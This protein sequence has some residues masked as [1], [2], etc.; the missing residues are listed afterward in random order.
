MKKKISS[1]Q[2]LILGL[3]VVA[4]T[5][6]GCPALASGQ[7]RVENPAR[8]LAKNAGR[9]VHL[10][11]ALRIRDNGETVVFKSPRDFSLGPDGSLFFTDFADGPRLYRFGPRG[12]LVYR[13]LKTGQGPGECQ[14][15][16]G[17][18]VAGD[19]VRVLAWSPPKIMDFDL[20]GGRYLRESRVDEDS[21][22]LWFLGMAGGKI[23]GVRDEVFSQ[24][25]FQS[26]GQA[27]IPNGVYEISADLKS[28][29]KLYEFPVR[30]MIKRR[31]A[32]R[33]D[34]IDAAIGGS[35]LYIVHTAEYGVTE[36]D[37]QTGA[38][39]RVISRAYDRVRARP[40]KPGDVD[41]ET[42]GV[43]F[44][45]DPFVWDIDKIQAAAGKLWVFTSVAKPDGDDRQV[46]VFDA[47]GRYIDRVI[48]RFP[49]AGLNHR[50]AA[51]W[52]LLTDDGFFIIPEEDKDGLISIGKYR[53]LD[54]GLFPG[55]RR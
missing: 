12:E 40:Q 49:P 26:G 43:E 1:E 4:T 24:A 21:H 28:W 8:A 19:R 25:S 15:P 31:N 14:Y 22:G 54:A 10:E 53:I 37:L 18:I 11:E 36:I 39:K 38:A 52:S 47:E 20:A 55:G 5:F 13:L 16:A 2:A 17:F 33:L 30:M 42:K 46:D 34:P 6:A 41:P 3:A 35:T 29:K 7:E 51:R 48:L 44:P 23:Y 50:S 9:V 32:F 27:T 45:E